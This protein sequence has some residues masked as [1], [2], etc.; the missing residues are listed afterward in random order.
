MLGFD[1]LI[2]EY[3]YYDPYMSLS[4]DGDFCNINIE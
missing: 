1:Y 2:A 3:R 4:Y